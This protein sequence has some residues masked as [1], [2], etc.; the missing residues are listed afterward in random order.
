MQLPNWIARLLAYRRIALAVHLLDHPNPQM[1]EQAR[2][3][4]KE[5]SPA[6]RPLLRR[7]ALRERS[8]AAAAAAELLDELG[9]RQGIYSLLSQYADPFMSRHFGPPLRSALQRIGQKRI[10][11]ELELSLG[12][13]ETPPLS[14]DQWPLALAVYSIHALHGLNARLSSDL[15]RRAVTASIPHLEDM[16]V[17]RSIVPAPYN[18]DPIADWRNSSTLVSVRRA[19]ID[20]LLTLEPSQAFDLLRD[21]LHHP[22]V[23]VQFTAIYGLRRL[24]DPRAYVL[25]QPIAADRKHPLSRDARRTIEAIGPSEPDAL[26]L[27]RAS[28]LHPAPPA[29]L[30]RPA[31]QEPTAPSDHLLHSIETGVRDNQG[32]GKRDRS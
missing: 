12:R 31:G 5:W 18:G 15:W 1:R 28:S 25:L 21:A 11:D 30:L 16:R 20:A 13:I 26:M 22:D 19:A 9:D 8:S 32:A 4:L 14:R 3:R 27:V 24:R 7:V 17:C 2:Q 10:T 23:Q 6:C 29:E